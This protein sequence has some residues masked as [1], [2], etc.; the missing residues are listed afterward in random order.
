L[1]QHHYLGTLAGRQW[2]Y[3]LIDDRAPD[4]TRALVGVAVFGPGMPN[5][6]P[7]LF[8]GLRTNQDSTEL[9]R[10]GLK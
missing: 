1:K 6:L 5:V 2:L 7:A 8:P 3:G 9:T 4:A 10:F